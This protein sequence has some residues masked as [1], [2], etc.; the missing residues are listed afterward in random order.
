MMYEDFIKDFALRTLENL[1]IICKHKEDRDNPGYEVTQLV[2][3]CVGLL[4]FPE[5]E[6]FDT[7]WKNEPTMNFPNPQIQNAAGQIECSQIINETPCRCVSHF[8]HMLRH[9]RNAVAHGT[10]KPIPHV[11]MEEIERICFT[12]RQIEINLS[13]GDVF[14]MLMSILCLILEGKFP[15]NKAMKCA[16]RF[17]TV[18]DIDGVR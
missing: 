6:Y 10:I 1:T 7:L 16:K 11:P 13:I 9:L 4:L 5:A 17:K 3:S 15:R 12:D 14:N 2:N 8:G 18:L